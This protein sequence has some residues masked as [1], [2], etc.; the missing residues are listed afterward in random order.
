MF[1]LEDSLF[2]GALARLATYGSL[3]PMPTYARGSD[4]YLV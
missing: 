4:D 1:G 2:S 3:K